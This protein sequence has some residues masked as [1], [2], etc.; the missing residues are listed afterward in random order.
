MRYLIVLLISSKIL[1]AQPSS[2]HIER[3]LWLIGGHL[4]NLLVR[5]S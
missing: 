3:N 2:N 5:P 1:F 4:Y